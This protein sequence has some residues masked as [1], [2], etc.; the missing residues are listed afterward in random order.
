MG[1]TPRFALS[2]NCATA[3]RMMATG[4]KPSEA[5]QSKPVPAHRSI[6]LR[7]LRVAIALN[8]D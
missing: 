1:D 4:G 8:P 7:R 5:A 3:S 6:I 2:N